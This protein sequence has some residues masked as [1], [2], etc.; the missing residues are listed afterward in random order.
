[1][2]YNFRF[3]NREDTHPG[4]TEYLEEG[5]L[6]VRRSERNFSRGTHDITIEQTE[7]RDA[8][9]KLTGIQAFKDSAPC[10]QRWSTSK[11]FRSGV[12]TNLKE[13]AGLGN[14]EDGSSKVT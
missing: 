5:A 1:M 12:V 2:I 6:S 10:R 13:M 3:L 11:F 8:A 14:K 7:N 9:S 4:I